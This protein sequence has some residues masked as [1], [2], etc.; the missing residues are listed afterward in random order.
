MGGIYEDEREIGVG[1]RTRLDGEREDND[2]K[3]KDRGRLV[4]SGGDVHK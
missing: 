2:E 3:S 4:E 1:K